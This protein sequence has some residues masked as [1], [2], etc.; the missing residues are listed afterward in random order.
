[1]RF[2]EETQRRVAQQSRLLLADEFA[3]LI[4]GDVFVVP[5]FRF[6]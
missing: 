5:L 6:R 1:V 2:R 4:L 3:H